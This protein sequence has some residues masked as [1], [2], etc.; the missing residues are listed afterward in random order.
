MGER[1]HYLY[2][3]WWRLWKGMEADPEGRGSR[4]TRFRRR[5]GRGHRQGRQGGC[6]SG[7]T[8]ASG[9]N[10]RAPSRVGVRSRT[11][12]QHNLPGR[13]ASPRRPWDIRGPYLKLKVESSDQEVLP[14]DH[15]GKLPLLQPT[16]W[17]Y[18]TLQPGLLVSVHELYSVL[19]AHF[20][21]SSCWHCR[22]FVPSKYL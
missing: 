19:Y 12:L 8:A 18:R 4:G 22:C 14:L 21:R 6:E 9:A 10:N 11:H 20:A 16:S 17:L 13:L 5:T 15:V 7:R 2:R 1:N 3:Y